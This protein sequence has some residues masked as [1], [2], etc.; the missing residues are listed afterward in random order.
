M[1]GLSDF[2]KK[3]KAEKTEQEINWHKVRQ[4]WIATLNSFFSEIELWLKEEIEEGLI[5]VE[6]YSVSLNEEHIGNYQAP[7]LKIK[8]LD[9]VIHL[10]PVGRL[11]IGAR[12]RVDMESLKGRETLLFLSPDEGWVHLQEQGRKIY[13][14]LT[15]DQFIDIL[16]GFLA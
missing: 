1:S 3:K 7:A 8:A 5:Q 6:H 11:I 15:K 16:K 9:E 2:L 13:A 10:K 14:R 12:G 4:E